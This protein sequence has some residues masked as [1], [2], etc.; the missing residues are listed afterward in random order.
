M[1]LINIETDDV[2]FS[3]GENDEPITNIPNELIHHSPDG[4][5]FGYA[6]SGPAEFA[7]NILYAFTKDKQLSLI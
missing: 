6:G 4:F 3:R 5:N 7:L 2:I 1:K